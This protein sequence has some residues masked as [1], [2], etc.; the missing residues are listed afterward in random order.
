MGRAQH[1]V[2]A[3]SA[4]L[5]ILRLVSSRLGK[6]DEGGF[7]TEMGFPLFEK[8]VSLLGCLVM[9]CDGNFIASAV[10]GDDEFER[11]FVGHMLFSFSFV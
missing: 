9:R 1:G 3:G 4:F 8:V 6:H 7:R 2:A 10:V 11:L 5:G